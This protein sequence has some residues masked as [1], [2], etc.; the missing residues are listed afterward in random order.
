MPEP[1][2]KL[3]RLKRTPLSEP[4]MAMWHAWMH[5]W[6]LYI[7][8]QDEMGEDGALQT[9]QKLVSPRIAEAASA[10]DSAP[11]GFRPGQIRLLGPGLTPGSDRPVYVLIL[12]E[13]EDDWRLVTPF[14]PFATPATPGECLTSRSEPGLRVLSVWNTHSLP[15]DLYRKSWWID[16]LRAE[17]VDLAWSVFRHVMAGRE[18]PAAALNRTGPPVTQ[19][20]DP[21][22]RYQEREA[23][24]MSGLASLARAAAQ[25]EAQAAAIESFATRY[26][27]EAR[28]HAAQALDVASR[29]MRAHD[30]GN[31]FARAIA[32]SLPPEYLLEA[33]A[34]GGPGDLPVVEPL[35]LRFETL[36]GPDPDEPGQCAAAWALEEPSAD[37]W[38]NRPFLVFS[39]LHH[40]IIGYGSI[41]PSGRLARLTWG[42]WADFEPMR[43]NLDSLVLIVWSGQPEDEFAS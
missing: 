4:Q 22:L 16:E 35:R 12:R 19:S 11:E 33:L 37:R 42:E 30:H 21:R 15:P 41:S 20:S 2:K 39:L 17:D 1:K 26:R 32:T 24:L 34:E 13:W 7:R 8:L 27:P 29:Q 14:G 3:P 18:L 25:R 9:S 5:E 31:P 6:D 43:G 40:Q 36:P 28:A 38:G 10:F 23:Q